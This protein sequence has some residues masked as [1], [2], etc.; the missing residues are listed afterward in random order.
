MK[1]AANL[2]LLGATR[3]DLKY[4]MVGLSHRSVMAAIELYGKQVVP[5]VRELLAAT[6]A[7]APTAG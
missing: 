2:P 5:R 4:G 3:F 1:I 7:P 6:D